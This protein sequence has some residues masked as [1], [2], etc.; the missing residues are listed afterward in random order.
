MT[1]TLEWYK[2]YADE[3]GYELTDKAEKVI[4]LVDKCEGYCP[5]KK[6]LWEKNRPEEMDKIIC[7]CQESPDEIEK[8]GF[9]H[10][11]LF[12]KKEQ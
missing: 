2:Q 9:C 3:H 1:H 11:R 4:E 8:Q 5:C 7:P 10:C 12:K 6:F